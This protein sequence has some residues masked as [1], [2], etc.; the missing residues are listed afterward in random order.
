[1]RV[2]DARITVTRADDRVSTGAYRWSQRIAQPD[3]HREEVV[4]HL[5][6][7]DLG[8]IHRQLARRPQADLLRK[9]E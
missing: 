5:G 9:R 2:I 8:T 1:M 4:R 6:E 7:I 3:R